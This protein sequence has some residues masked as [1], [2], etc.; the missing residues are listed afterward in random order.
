MVGGLH[1]DLL[2]HKAHSEVCRK[3]WRHYFAAVVVVPSAILSRVRG[4]ELFPLM[5]RW[6]AAITDGKWSARGSRVVVRMRC[7]ISR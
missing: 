6:A 5:H 1:F 2:E 7:L 4:E 3:N